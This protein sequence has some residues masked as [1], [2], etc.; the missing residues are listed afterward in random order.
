M[1]PRAVFTRL[2]GPGRP[3][4]LLAG[5]AVVALVSVA[6]YTFTRRRGLRFPEGLEVGLL[7]TMMPILSPQG[8][9]YVFLVST[10]AVMYLVNYA[11]ALPRGL[12][13]AVTAALVIIAFSIY[14]LMG[15][16]AY[17]AFMSWSG[18]TLCY[19][20]VLAGLTALRANQVA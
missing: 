20:V 18:I 8:W 1:S 4:D 16:A 12:R 2:L 13:I 19:L 15:R 3:A 7:L 5:C 10:P 11:D 6:V 9:D 14:D 17:L